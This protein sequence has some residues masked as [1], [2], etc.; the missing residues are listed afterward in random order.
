M[1][2]IG[3]TRVCIL[4]KQEC[5]PDNSTKNVR[6]SEARLSKNDNW[7]TGKFTRR[8]NLTAMFVKPQQ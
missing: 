1:G 2:R 4:V 8:V 5:T 6:M 7:R 3:Q